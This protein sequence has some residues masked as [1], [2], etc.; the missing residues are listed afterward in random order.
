MQS[1]PVSKIL[2]FSLN[3][4]LLQHKQFGQL[5]TP[6]ILLTVAPQKEKKEKNPLIVLKIVSTPTVE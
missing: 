2:E 3:I 4:S 1:K 6:L 5:S